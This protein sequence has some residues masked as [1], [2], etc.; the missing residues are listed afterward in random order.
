VSTGLLY[1]AFGI[2]GY[3]GFRTDHPGGRVIFTSASLACLASG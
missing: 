3:D 2:R 1:H